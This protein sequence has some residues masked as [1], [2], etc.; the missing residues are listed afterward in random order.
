MQ[1]FI[2][3]F[4][5]FFLHPRRNDGNGSSLVVYCSL[6]TLSPLFSCNDNPGFFDASSSPLTHD[7]FYETFRFGGEL[8]K[9]EKR[10]FLDLADGLQ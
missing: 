6:Q 5:V 3:L 7:S 9:V 2:R 10:D 4:S 1:P 8:D